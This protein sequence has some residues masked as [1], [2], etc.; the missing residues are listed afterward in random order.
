MNGWKHIED[1]KAG[2]IVLSRNVDNGE[3]GY[4][5]VVR[6][7]I[8]KAARLVRISLPGGMITSTPEH[9]FWVKGKGWTQSKDLSLKDILVDSSLFD[10][11][12]INIEAAEMETAVYNFEV[13]DWHTYFVGERGILVHNTCTWGEN[14]DKK[15]K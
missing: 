14:P 10:V 13:E 6:T 5:N 3:T 11:K 9:P 12:I 2:D 7:F 15:F 1:I 4:K 8:I